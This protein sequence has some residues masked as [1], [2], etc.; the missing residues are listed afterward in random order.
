MT[1]VLLADDH[2]MVRQGLRAMLERIAGL[3]VVG[4]AD[5]GQEAVKLAHRLIPDVVVMD[6]AMPKLNG[7]EATRRLR[8]EL[9]KIKVVALSMHQDRQFV[10]GMLKAGA[11]GYLLKDSAFRELSTALGEVMAGRTYLCPEVAQVVVGEMH[12]PQSPGD[13]PLAQLTSREREIL[14]LIAE[15]KASK[16][17]AEMLNISIKTV[18]THRRNIMEKMQAKNLAELTRLALRH[19]LTQL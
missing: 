9:P 19:G 6:V 12:Q 1:K 4:E 5:D 13:Q 16:E 2:R 14:Q 11:S 3:E 15:A 10:M 8:Q 17:I 18:Y 7:I